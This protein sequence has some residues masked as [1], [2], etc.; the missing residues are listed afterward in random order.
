MWVFSAKRFV[1]TLIIKVIS[2]KSRFPNPLFK[3][4]SLTQLF[5]NHCFLIYSLILSTT[6]ISSRAENWSVC[7]SLTM[8]LCSSHAHKQPLWNSQSRL[9]LTCICYT[10]RIVSACLTND[11][12]SCVYISRYSTLT[13]G[14]AQYSPFICAHTILHTH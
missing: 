2:S 13:V 6:V 10:F 8:F 3:K 4:T 5:Q 14:K 7:R 9:L 12:L 1:V 11:L